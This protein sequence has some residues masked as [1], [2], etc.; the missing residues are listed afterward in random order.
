MTS[1]RHP[2]AYTQYVR[3]SQSTDT[4][5]RWLGA[6]PEPI[7]PP[8]PSLSLP[9]KAPTPLARSLSQPPIMRRERRESTRTRLLPPPP[10]VVDVDVPTISSRSSPGHFVK[11]SSWVTLLLSGQEEGVSEPV[12]CNGATIE[13][14]L[15]VPRPAGLLKLE[16]KVRAFSPAPNPPPIDTAWNRSKGTSG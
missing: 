6:T 4:F 14:I 7:A 16:V 2:F 10:P 3:Y 11:H 15:A 1:T 8:V 12:F 9:V 13:G 5:T